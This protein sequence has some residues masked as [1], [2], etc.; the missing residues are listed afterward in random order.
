MDYKDLQKKAQD[1]QA[2]KIAE[3]QERLRKQKEKEERKA[4]EEKARQEER[5]RQEREEQERTQSFVS[6]MALLYPRMQAC[7]KKGLKA[8]VN[9]IDNILNEFNNLKNSN[10]DFY[11]S[12]VYSDACRIYNV[13]Q[14]TKNKIYE[15][16]RNK[17]KRNSLIKK[18]PLAAGCIA[19]IAGGGYGF[20][21]YKYT[22]A[23]KTK[24]ADRAVAK[25]K[26][27]EEKEQKRILKSYKVGGWGEAGVIFYDK[28]K[29]SDGWRFLEIAP[30]K[31]Q[32]RYFGIY[33]AEVEGLK[34]RIRYW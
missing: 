25:Q 29:Y 22:D 18:V 24:A 23:Y 20:L 11:Q 15:Q 28:G 16:Q 8:S 17:K 6:E 14:E 2:A 7:E 4:A 12:P 1:E 34:K 32:N 33:A 30:T 13:L 19:I 21:Q 26:K 9:E 27:A 31:S 5:E 10:V 3:E